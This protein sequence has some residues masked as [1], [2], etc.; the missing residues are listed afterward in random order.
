MQRFAELAGVSTCTLYAW[1]RRLAVGGVEGRKGKSQLVA[2]DVIG[3]DARSPVG[4]M[5]EIRFPNGASLRV[6]R[7][8][9][10]AR[11]SD[12]VAVIRAC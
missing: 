1:K 7:D 2:V 8:F 5:Y 9:D 3:R 10:I 12:L 4:D 6:P 11:V